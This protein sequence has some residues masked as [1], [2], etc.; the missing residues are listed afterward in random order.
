MCRFNEKRE[1][2]SGEN[3]RKEKRTVLS[4]HI[5]ITLRWKRM[6]LLIC[7][8]VR[9]NQPQGIEEYKYHSIISISSDSKLEQTSKRRRRQRRKEMSTR[10]H[11]P[12]RTTK[13]VPIERRERAK[14]TEGC[15]LNRKN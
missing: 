4:H 2:K 14:E 1:K 15:T 3:E 11:Y 7:I 6:D 12:I 5:E 10:R 9:E 8:S 13:F